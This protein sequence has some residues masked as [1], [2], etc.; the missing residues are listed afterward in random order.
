LPVKGN[1]KGLLESIEQLFDEAERVQ[2]KG[3]DAD[4]FESLE[5]S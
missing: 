2:F 1:H 3:V 5:K 4:H